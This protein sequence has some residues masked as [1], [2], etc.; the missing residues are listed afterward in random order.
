MIVGDRPFQSF[1]S[2]L[3]I[4]LFVLISSQLLGNV[5]VIQLAVPNIQPL[6]EVLISELLFLYFRSQRFLYDKRTCIYKYI[7]PYACILCS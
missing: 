1:T 7:H 2:V 5:A 3:G 4:S 6:P